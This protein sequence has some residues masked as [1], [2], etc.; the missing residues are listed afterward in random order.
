MANQGDDD[1]RPRLAALLRHSGQGN[2]TTG[3]STI[4]R[5][6]SP[7]I[8]AKRAGLPALCAY[9]ANVWQVL[10]STSV[11]ENTHD[12]TAIPERLDPLLV[13]PHGAGAFRRCRDSGVGIVP[14]RYDLGWRP[15]MFSLRP[16]RP[17]SPRREI[18]YR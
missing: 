8:G 6:A 12:F 11:P 18:A 13:R 16:A 9:A 4:R 14:G 1:I 17:W 10:S 7:M 3:P 5:R 2:P 15:M